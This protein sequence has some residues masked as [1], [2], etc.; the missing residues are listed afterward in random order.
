[1][2]TP[3]SILEN[4]IAVNDRYASNYRKAGKN[5]ARYVAK[6]AAYRA[7]LSA[8]KAANISSDPQIAEI[9]L[10]TAIGLPPT[11][12]AGT[13]GGSGDYV[14][15]PTQ[16]IIGASTPEQ[17]AEFGLLGLFGTPDDQATFP[18]ADYSLFQKYNERAGGSGWQ[19][20]AEF[21][22]PP[23]AWAAYVASKG[24]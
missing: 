14:S 23:G 1:M 7:A 19:P 16:A 4:A 17:N 22:N 5:P 24:Q 3:V 13:I 9:Q 15:A 12:R 10:L 18:T 21:A 8:L 6:A 20:K 11:R 2:S